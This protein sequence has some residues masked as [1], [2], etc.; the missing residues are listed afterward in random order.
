VA[1]KYFLS[2]SLI[3]SRQKIGTVT[4]SI[5]T[6]HG[7]TDLG[8]LIGEKTVWGC[9]YGIDAWRTLARWVEVEHGVRKITG[10]AL[11]RNKA[12]IRILQKSKFHLEAVL[13]KQEIYCGV[14]ED[15]LLYARFCK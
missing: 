10:G 13:R 7:T 14:P 9:G 2:V 1:G 5:N 4:A 6:D 3:D 8:I 11:A 12:M 15:I